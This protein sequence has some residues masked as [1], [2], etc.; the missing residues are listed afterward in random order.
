MLSEIFPFHF[1]C[2]QISIRVYK[3]FQMECSSLIIFDGTNHIDRIEIFRCRPYPGL[4]TVVLMDLS[5]FNNLQGQPAVFF[6]HP[7]R[8]TPRFPI[9]PHHR[10]NTQR[11]IKDGKQNLL[12]DG[13]RLFCKSFRKNNMEYMAAIVLN[14]LTFEPS[15]CSPSMSCKKE[16]ISSRIR[17]ANPPKIFL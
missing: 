14:F 2:N 4:M 17:R 15:P 10:A 1:L 16:N 13:K 11:A 6:L 7:K 8:C 5:R 3:I 12:F 9:I